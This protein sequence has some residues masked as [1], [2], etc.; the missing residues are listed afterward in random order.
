M[1]GLVLVAGAMSTVTAVSA[2]NVTSPGPG[3]DRVHLDQAGSVGHRP[4][5]DLVDRA[6]VLEDRM[7]SGLGAFGGDNPGTDVPADVPGVGGRH[8]T[9]TPAPV[10][11]RPGDRGVV[12]QVTA[13]AK[14][15]PA[16]DPGRSPGS[17]RGGAHGG[18]GGGEHGA[19]GAAAASAQARS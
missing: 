12:D 18:S 19:R 10:A 4:R 6:P 13:S 9:P 3:L 14:V 5:A 1:I 2:V 11:P 17:A 7:L 16:P 8:A 15:R